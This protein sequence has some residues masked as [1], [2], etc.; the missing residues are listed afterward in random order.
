MRRCWPAST[1][2][3]GTNARPSKRPISITSAPFYVAIILYVVAFLLAIFG[4]LLR[5][6]PLNWAAFTLSGLTF[7]LHTVALAAR[8][9]I[10]GRPPVTNLYSSAVFIGWGSRAVGPG[11]RS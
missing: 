8:I 10:S 5:Y 7:V 3:C 6:R 9:Y 11:A 2:R 4:W 1:R